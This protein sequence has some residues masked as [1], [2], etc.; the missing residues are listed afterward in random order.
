[1]SPTNRQ[2]TDDNESCKSELEIPYKMNFSSSEHNDDDDDSSS[3]DSSDCVSID[4][5]PGRKRKN[6]EPLRVGDVIQYT[7]AVFC[8]GTHQRRAVVLGTWP[9]EQR[10]PL[11]LDNG[12]SLPWDTNIQ[13]VGEYHKGE[14][15]RHAGRIKEISYFY[16]QPAGTKDITLGHRK[17]A[18]QYKQTIQH[19]ERIAM[20]A[21]RGELQVAPPPTTDIITNSAKTKRIDGT[22]ISS[23]SSSSFSSMSAPIQKT[24]AENFVKKHKPNNDES[25]LSD[26]IPCAVYTFKTSPKAKSRPGLILSKQNRRKS[27]SVMKP[28]SRQRKETSKHQRTASVQPRRSNLS[29]WNDQ[30]SSSDDDST[31]PKYFSRQVQASLQ[32]EKDKRKQFVIKT[33]N[34]YF[35][36]SDDE[37]IEN[38]PKRIIIERIGKEKSVGLSVKRDK[39][40]I[41]TKQNRLITSMTGLS[42]DDDDDEKDEKT[43]DLFKPVFRSQSKSQAKD[44]KSSRH[45]SSNS[46]SS[47]DSNRKQR[48]L[49][50]S[51]SSSFKRKQL[52]L[53]SSSEDDGPN[54]SSRHR[55]QVQRPAKSDSIQSLQ[56]SSDCDVD[57]PSPGPIFSRHQQNNKQLN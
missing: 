28:L 44:A 34:H 9:K 41:N 35:S 23:S 46:N 7:P 38:Y 4:S 10:F 52:L 19:V 18:Q 47:P 43:L 32:K 3:S 54:H 53:S 21:L 36:G 15:Y 24:A 39:K 17:K 2:Q 31:V 12:D 26:S 8:A 27:Q 29:Q 37:D 48:I 56:W 45:G 42:S 14:V 57:S 22:S 6:R 51:P 40:T 16:L 55:L 1:M 49:R 5:N 50:P 25:T 13:R 20:Q 33:T 30:A 11:V